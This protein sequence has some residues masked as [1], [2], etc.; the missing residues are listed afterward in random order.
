MY[1][2]FKGTVAEKGLDYCVLDV[3]DIGYV[4][5][6]SPQTISLL[7][8]I[9]EEIKLYTYTVV[10]EDDLSLFGFLTRDDL[11]MFELLISV[12]GIG[13]KGGQAILSVMSADEV[14]FAILAGDYKQIAK[15]PGIGGKTAQKVILELKDKISVKDALGVVSKE[16]AA[17]PAMEQAL[18]VK[19]ATEALVALG[20]GATEAAGAVSKVPD[21]E[22][23]TTEQI[24]KNA[25]KY[26][27]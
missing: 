1:G 11:S 16:I 17:T 10:R 15:A 20:Y 21:K 22:T 8:S 5:K 13:P 26:L 12:N 25:L 6:L 4:I 24:L 18:Q 23:L 9:G 7:P 19:E 3:H 14:R 2:Y 27:F